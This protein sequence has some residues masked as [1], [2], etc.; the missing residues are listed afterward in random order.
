MNESILWGLYG[1]GIMTIIFSIKSM[2]TKRPEITI[3]PASIFGFVSFSIWK[4]FYDELVKLN[5]GWISPALPIL[6]GLG[7][8]LTG[9]SLV[10]RDELK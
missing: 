4:V 5:L 6:L 3:I 10:L 9:L 8:F 7:I 2:I 1:A